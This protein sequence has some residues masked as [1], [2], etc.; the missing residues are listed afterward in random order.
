M[1][2]PYR[3]CQPKT[4]YAL[5]YVLDCEH[6]PSVLAFACTRKYCYFATTGLLSSTIKFELNDPQLARYVRM[7]RYKLQTRPSS[8]DRWPT[9]TARRPSLIL[10]TNGTDRNSPLKTVVMTIASLANPSSYFYCRRQPCGCYLQD[11]R[12]L[13]AAGQSDQVIFYT[14][15]RDLWMSNWFPPRILQ[16]LHHHQL[17]CIL[18]INQFNLHSRNASVTNA[19]KFMLATSSYLCSIMTPCNRIGSYDKSG[20]PIY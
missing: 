11:Q 3:A 17:R 15:R 14:N 12:C 10:N 4:Y 1:L 6:T 9:T 16:I 7:S 8:C 13:G 20:I 5:A 2:Q 19:H 18:L